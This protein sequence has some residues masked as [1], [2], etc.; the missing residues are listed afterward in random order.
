MAE[1]HASP[2]D[3]IWTWLSSAAVGFAIVCLLLLTTGS[4]S[5]FPDPNA[6]VQNDHKVTVAFYG[7]LVG[8]AALSSLGFLALT[9]AKTPFAKQCVAWPKY[10]LLEGETRSVMVARLAFIG[11]LLPQVTGILVASIAY[12][13]TSKIA[14]WNADVPLANGFVRSRLAA[15]RSDCPEQPCFRLA[16]LDGIPPFAHQWFITSD[17]LVVLLLSCAIALWVVYAVRIARLRQN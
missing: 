9:Y 1:D 13:K 12:A 6:V 15:F 7:V 11:V 3:T 4:A 2:Y 17:I 5:I 16:P 10:Q 8:T 14:A